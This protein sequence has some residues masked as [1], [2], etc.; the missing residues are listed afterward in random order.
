M[1]DS[2]VPALLRPTAAEFVPGQLAHPSPASSERVSSPAT[3][4]QQGF[5]AHPQYQLPQHPQGLPYCSPG[6]YGYQPYPLY[7]GY[8]HYY[9]QVHNPFDFHATPPM[10]YVQPQGPMWNHEQFS[11]IEYTADTPEPFTNQH[12]EVNG[13]RAGT[14]PYQNNHQGRY[15]NGNGVDPNTGLR[16]RPRK[17]NR[18]KYNHRARGQNQNQ[19]HDQ[20]QDHDDDD[21][22]GHEQQQK[23]GGEASGTYRR[24][25]PRE[26]D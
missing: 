7:D 1:S 23:P 13:V 6:F 15:Q 22:Q 3:P 25:P 2:P 18:R 12:R 11:S 10:N 21:D 5:N 16:R 26:Q 17:N 24:N 14:M 19:D 20:D 8:T 4:P 9:N